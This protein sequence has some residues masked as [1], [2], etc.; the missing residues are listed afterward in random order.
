LLLS[1]DTP[2]L[3]LKKKKEEGCEW[4]DVDVTLDIRPE[5]E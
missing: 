5:Y 1:G 4:Y 2:T 3:P